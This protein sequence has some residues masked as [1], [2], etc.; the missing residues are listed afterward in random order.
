R[1]HAVARIQARRV[2]LVAVPRPAGQSR[3][4]RERALGAQE[5]GV[6]GLRVGLGQGRP[7]VGLGVRQGFL[8][9]LGGARQRVGRVV[10]RREVHERRQLVARRRHVRQTRVGGGREQALVELAVPLPDLV[11][12]VF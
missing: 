10:E 7:A 11:L 1:L 2:D 3:G 4:A 9:A 12:F 5:G 8:I 6:H